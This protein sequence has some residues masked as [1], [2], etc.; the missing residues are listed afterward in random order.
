MKNLYGQAISQKLL[1]DNF[2]WTENTSEFDEDFI[3][4][5]DEATDWGYI[6]DVDVI[7]LKYLREEHNDVLFLPEIVKIDKCNKCMCNLFNKKKYVIYVTT[8]M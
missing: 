1:V 3:K 5:S 2:E 7:Y 6:L 8:L 4:F